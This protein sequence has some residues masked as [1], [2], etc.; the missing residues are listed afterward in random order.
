MIH[1]V[2]DPQGPFALFNRHRF[3]ANLTCDQSE[4]VHS[5][6]FDHYR[7]DFSLQGA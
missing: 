4:A 7:S 2:R 1:Y 6:R 3:G 5:H